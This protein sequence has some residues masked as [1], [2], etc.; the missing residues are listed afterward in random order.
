MRFVPL[1]GGGAAPPELARPA[2]RPT[3]VVTRSTVADPRRDRMMTTVVE[4]AE[5]ADIDVVLVRPDRW[6]TRRRLPTNVRTVG[7]L[8]FAEVFPN[9]AGVVHHGGSGTLMTALASGVPQLVVPGPGDRA[10]HARLLAE[11][12]AG[13]AVPLDRLDGAALER[14]V[15]DLGL[16]AAAREV[17]AEVA[18]MPHPADLVDDLAGLAR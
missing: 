9:L 1:D 8:P 7:W 15:G 11:R 13:L 2:S 4:A 5:G 16:R 6:V 17:A 12:G 14:L 10:L 18:A 3:V